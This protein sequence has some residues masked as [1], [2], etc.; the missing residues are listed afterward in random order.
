MVRW[1]ACAAVALAGCVAPSPA[2]VAHP[3]LA[4][5]RLPEIPGDIPQ[6]IHVIEID[7]TQ[8]GVALEVSPKEPA[9]GRQYRAQ[10]TSEFAARHKLQAAVNGAFF[11]PFRGGT[12]FGDDFHPRS[13][14]PVDATPGPK[15][16]GTVCIV[17]PA[18]V[19][20]EKGDRC[21]G[22]V[23]H[24]LTAGPMLLAD[25]ER[26][27]WT[28]K[29]A[30]HPRTAFGVSADGRRAWMVVVDGRQQSSGGA[31][32]DE[33]AAI[34]RR[35]GASDAVNFD[36]GGSTTMVFDDGAGPRVVNSPIHTGIP[37]RERPSATHLGVRAPILPRK[38][39]ER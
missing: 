25:G 19:T 14:D 2:P 29:P 15:P 35:L 11:E 36:G 12:P 6:A 1:A 4:Y 23:D 34:L 18:R 33:M 8:P 17:A 5:S 10:T 32:L 7:L 28:L 31:T 39:G 30:H 26:Q 37:G 21:A 16:N 24:A 27:S 13:G 22:A 9:G 3:A 38:G 20:V